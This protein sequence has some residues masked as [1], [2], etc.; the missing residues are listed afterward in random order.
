MIAEGVTIANWAGEA[1]VDDPRL[2]FPLTCCDRQGSTGP[3]SEQKNSEKAVA[4]ES[5]AELPEGV[6]LEEVYDPEDE[7]CHWPAGVGASGASA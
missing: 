5:S 3:I 4:E 2:A 6:K 1:Q 7:V